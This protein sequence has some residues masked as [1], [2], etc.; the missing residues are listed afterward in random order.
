MRALLYRPLFLVLLP[1]A[2]VAHG[3]SVQ[4][5][6][7]GIGDA[8]LISIATT[9]VLVLFSIVLQLVFR[10]RTTAALSA[11]LFGIVALYWS[12]PYLRV[13]AA[14]GDA[15][16]ARLPVL[17]AVILLLWGVSSWA[18]HRSRDDQRARIALF[19]NLLF[20]ILFLVDGTTAI[21]RYR[22]ALAALPPSLLAA[23]TSVKPPVFI[24]LFDEYG[25]PA[26]LERQGIS[27]DGVEPFLRSQGFHTV[28]AARSAYPITHFSLAAALNSFSLPLQPSKPVTLTDY[29]RALV[30]IRHS[31]IVDAF[32]RS[33]Y[34]IHNRSVFTLGDEAPFEG[35]S[36]LVEGTDVLV[37]GTLWDDVL[38]PLW[39]KRFTPGKLQQQ[40]FDGIRRNTALVNSLK[41]DTVKGGPLF[42]YA[43]FFL[44]HAPFLYDS[45]G[46]QLPFDTSLQLTADNNPRGYAANLRVATGLLKE[47]VNS[48]RKQCPDAIILVMGDHGYRNDKLPGFDTAQ[49]Q[50]LCAV[51]YPDGNYAG[52][53]DSLSLVN[54][55]RFVTAK[56]LGQTWQALPET[57]TP[58]KDAT[59]LEW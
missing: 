6:R 21:L 16:F 3:L 40:Y 38:K 10:K 39:L 24:L 48:I 45:L 12:Y 22:A 2:F 49:F 55:V 29:N 57:T 50:A 33:G 31:R 13:K 30:W 53:R 1:L 36:P 15:A 4:F 42:S 18:I 9:G 11:A 58:L 8:V 37:A 43:H 32:R 47:S 20:G 41:E 56:A 26:T 46:K 59:G 17:L 5:G 34:A 54:A 28:P 14:F 23:G 52:W 19:F 7:A 25:S 51:Y 44:P 35:H 27:T